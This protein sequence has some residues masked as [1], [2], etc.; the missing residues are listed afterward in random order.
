MSADGE[1]NGQV[2]PPH[3]TADEA[4]VSNRSAG[5]R[6]VNIL[7]EVTQT[8]GTFFVL[9]L[10]AYMVLAHIE[11]KTVDAALMMILGMYFTRT[12]HTKVGG[13]GGTD[14]R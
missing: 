5:Q 11:D 9:I 13:V 4:E 12:N 8:S 10:K 6:R 14:S 2:V 3:R 1:V 7:W